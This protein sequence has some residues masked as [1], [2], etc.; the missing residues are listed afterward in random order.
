MHFIKYT[1]DNWLPNVN[2]FTQDD[3]ITRGFVNKFNVLK[4][5]TEDIT[6]TAQLNLFK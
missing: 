4:N 6:S 3:E 5:Q 1:V 2:A